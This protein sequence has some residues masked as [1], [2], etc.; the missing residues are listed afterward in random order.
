MALT[1]EQK[2]E[3]L[4]NLK[5]K[6][7]NSKSIVFTKNLGLNTKD[8][9]LL[10]DQLRKENIEYTISKKTIIKLAAKDIGI[11]EIEDSY[12]EGPVG[13]AYSYD[14]QVSAARI[15]HKFSKTNKNIELLGGILDGG[16]IDNKRVKYLAVLPTKPELLSKLIGTMQ[17]P[18]RGFV[19]TLSGVMSGFVRTLNA[20][21]E[22][23][24]TN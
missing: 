2:N 12:I 15:L 13:V 11:E 23:K 1:K 21:K 19:G 22:Q 9:A 17:N 10:R 16:L 8:I 6:F 4:K 7:K 20:I 18:V 14:D 3:L 24:E 5:E